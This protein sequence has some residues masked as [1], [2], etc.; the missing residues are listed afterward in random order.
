MFLESGQWRLKC[1]IEHPISFGDTPDFGEP[2]GYEEPPII[3]T[4]AHFL[5][6][7]KECIVTYMHNGI[8]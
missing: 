6:Q 4:S 7:E 5:L 1:H 3:A 8:W 2:D